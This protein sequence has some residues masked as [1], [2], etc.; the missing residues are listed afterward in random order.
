MIQVFLDS[1]ENEGAT[2]EDIK[3]LKNF[4]DL[5]RVCKRSMYLP[6]NFEEQNYGFKTKTQ[7]IL[8][9][10]LCDLDKDR[11]HVPKIEDFLIDNDFYDDN[12]ETDTLILRNL[13][14]EAQESLVEI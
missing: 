12:L 10:D 6:A 1:D 9:N 4:D 7:N 14:K 3:D 2:I 13:L 11:S 8:L 5:M